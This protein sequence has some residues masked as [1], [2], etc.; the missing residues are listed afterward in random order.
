MSY[1]KLK[2]LA[3]YIGVIL[4]CFISA[5]MLAEN[6]LNH[7]VGAC[8]V[9]ILVFMVSIHTLGIFEMGAI[10]SNLDRV[11]SLMDQLKKKEQE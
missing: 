6:I 1:I 8:L 9:W 10:I 4:S 7:N 2:M 11:P 3:L 5:N